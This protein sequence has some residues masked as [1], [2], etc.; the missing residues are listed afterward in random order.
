VAGSMMK[1]LIL[2]TS[3]SPRVNTLVPSFSSILISYLA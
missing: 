1:R 3:S 2:P